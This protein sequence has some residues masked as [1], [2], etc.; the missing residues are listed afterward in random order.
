M[1]L[2]HSTAKGDLIVEITKEERDE[3]QKKRTY[4]AKEILS[5]ELSY[6]NSINQ[7]IEVWEVNPKIRLNFLR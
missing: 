5:T 2:S 1:G 3:K 4:I 6:V 7:A